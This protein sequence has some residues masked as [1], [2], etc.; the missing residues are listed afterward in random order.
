MDTKKNL[1]VKYFIAVLFTLLSIVIDQFTKYLA[2][3][4]LKDKDP[5][6]L[7]KN[8]FELRYLENRGMAFGMLENKQFIFIIGALI[9]C[10]VIIYV[11]G[12]IPSER[13][14]LPLK[15]CSIL[16]VGG[17]IGNL[18]DRIRLNYVIDFFYFKLIDFPIFNVADCYVVIACIAF[19][20]LI[21]FY[22]KDEDFAFLKFKK[23]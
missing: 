16:L 5:F 13:R 1:T 19:A 8:V 11:Y 14:Y 17:A 2:V 7:I 20:I 23:K 9:I 21:L 6:I 15:A 22:Y 3:T 10:S 4:R 12:K 18:I